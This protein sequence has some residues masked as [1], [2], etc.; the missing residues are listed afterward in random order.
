MDGRTGI[1]EGMFLLFFPPSLP[2]FCTQGLRPK[3]RMYG[4]FP[5]SSLTS[6]SSSFFV[7]EGRRE[8]GS[9]RKRVPRRVREDG[10]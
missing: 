1:D 5:A 8:E 4:L 10:M 7:K 6:F 3:A 2:T 9:E